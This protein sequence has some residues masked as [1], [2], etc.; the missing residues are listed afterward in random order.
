[1]IAVIQLLL[2]ILPWLHSFK[3]GS[4]IQVKYYFIQLLNKCRSDFVRSLNW[5]KLIA[6]L[7]VTGVDVLVALHKRSKST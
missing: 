6:R 1:M 2:K 5:L 3:I 7:K 4:L